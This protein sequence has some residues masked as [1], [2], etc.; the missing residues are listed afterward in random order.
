MNKNTWI[1]I[2]I[3]VV[4]A[5][6]GWYFGYDQGYESAIADIKEIGRASCRERV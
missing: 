4:V 2:V 6:G 3:G 1:I 5:F